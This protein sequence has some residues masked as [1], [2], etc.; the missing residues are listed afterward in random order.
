MKTVLIAV[1][2]FGIT[3]LNG[4]RIHAQG[5]TQI[6]DFPST[7][8][9]DGTSF[10]I[11]STTYCGTGLN[12]TWTPT[13]DFYAIDLNT[14]SWSPISGLPSAEARQYSNGFA[15]DTHGYLFGGLNG[16]GY[17]NDIWKY[18]PISDSWIEVSSL[19]SD[20]RSGASCFVIGD[21]AYILGGQ[22]QTSG[23]I[24]EVWAYSMSGDSWTQKNSLPES[25]WRASAISYQ[26]KGYLTL[27]VNNNGNYQNA[28]YE[29]SPS[30]D[31]WVLLNN[32]PGVGRTYSGMCIL[33][34]QLVIVAGRDSIGNSYNDMWRYSVASDSWTL[35][36]NLPS[37]QRRG[38]FCFS[39][40]TAI[41]YSA[42]INLND[43]RLTETWKYDLFLNTPDEEFDDFSIYPNPAKDFLKIHFA[44]SVGNLQ[45]QISSI[46]GTKIQSGEI[47][48][49]NAI[50]LDYFKPG[51]YLISIQN[52]SRSSI[53][54]FVI[55]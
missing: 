26:G 9:D 7:A 4:T 45:Y 40:N 14:D 17:L 12:S 50:P 22:T 52:E 11:G 13:N 28:L 15:S 47:G 16:A 49:N 37:D 30:T 18:D 53:K 27:G 25:L 23:A 20:G 36:E 42:G 2:F 24:S 32:F 19:P 3:L 31:T 10:S 38:A 33:E 54:K 41:Y 5:W 46:D 51:T 8:R 39:S 29:Y 35:S 34:D 1:L 6:D 48:N 55:Y 44:S 43:V 21:T